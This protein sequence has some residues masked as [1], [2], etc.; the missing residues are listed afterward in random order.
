MTDT[1]TE[2]AVRMRAIER[3]L[4]EI[5]LRLTELRQVTPQHPQSGVT[6]D[7]L[8]TARRHASEAQRHWHE[9]TMHVQVVRWVVVEAFRRAAQAHDQAADAIEKSAHARTGDVAGYRQTAESHRAA[10]EADRQRAAELQLQDE[11]AG[12]DA[13]SGHAEDE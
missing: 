6:N 5:R 13:G 1:A 7:V 2:V 10:A 11:L 9:S 4:D 12:E 3:R 8:A